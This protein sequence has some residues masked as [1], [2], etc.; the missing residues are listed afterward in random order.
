MDDYEEMET[1][2]VYSAKNCS[3]IIKLN[4]FGDIVY[5]FWNSKANRH[6]TKYIEMLQ[7]CPMMSFYTDTSIKNKETTVTF[8][9]NTYNPITN[10]TEPIYKK[11]AK[12]FLFFLGILP[13]YNLWLA[14][15]IKLNEICCDSDK[16]IFFEKV[17][18]CEYDKDDLIRGSIVETFQNWAK[19]WEK[20]KEY[21]DFLIKVKLVKDGDYQELI[22]SE[23]LKDRNS[24]PLNNWL[25][26]TRPSN[27]LV[28]FKGSE[29]RRFP[30]NMW[31][32]G[33][34]IAD[35]EFEE[36]EERVV[37]RKKGMHSGPSLVYKEKQEDVNHEY[38]VLKTKQEEIQTWLWEK[39]MQ[40]M[41]NQIATTET[42]P[43]ANEETWAKTTFG[44]R[45][46]Y[47]I[48]QNQGCRTFVFTESNKS[49]ILHESLK[50][51]INFCP[52]TPAAHGMFPKIEFRSESEII[53]ER[54]LISPNSEWEK[55]RKIQ[56]GRVVITFVLL[57]I[58][59]NLAITAPL[60][61]YLVV[62]RHRQLQ[63]N[64]FYCIPHVSSNNLAENLAI[65]KAICLFD[66]DD[67]DPHLKNLM[68]ILS[69]NC[70]LDL[71]VTTALLQHPYFSQEG[72]NKFPTLVSGV[73]E[74][75]LRVCLQGAKVFDLGN[76]SHATYK[77]FFDK[78][79]CL[80][81]EDRQFVGRKNLIEVS[82]EE[83][84]GFVVKTFEDTSDSSEKSVVIP[85]E[86]KVFDF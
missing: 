28:V 63:I 8:C 79:I 69:A 72:Y 19:T 48:D 44:Y 57:L 59:H 84:G 47:K 20:S 39:E 21:K 56:F 24:D 10:V 70:K 43:T 25:I 81:D 40:M 5:S 35:F 66:K 6:L 50:Y 78:W 3:L 46:Y 16:N 4:K 22:K 11:A 29:F 14:Q 61:D 62:N 18:L 80:F 2:S 74:N 45:E 76:V 58:K 31:L 51:F 23:F 52:F 32:N 41:G 17:V 77:E 15:S 33:E 26:F 13:S 34:A 27:E 65:Y 55:K 67:N 9:S 82:K 36:G 75:N 73:K 83:I 54:P 1:L 64:G 53:D 86:L 71:P 30:I 49:E 60:N 85:E 38:Y 7:E 42:A 12:T 37:V 68:N